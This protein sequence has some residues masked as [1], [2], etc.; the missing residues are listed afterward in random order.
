M[1]GAC[2]SAMQLIIASLIHVLLLI[3]VLQSFIIA[4]VTT[5]FRNF[6]SA[7]S[8]YIYIN[9]F[10]TVGCLDTTNSLPRQM[11]CNFKLYS[12]GAPIAYNINWN[13]NGWIIWGDEINSWWPVPGIHIRMRSLL[14]AI[15]YYCCIFLLVA[16]CELSEPERATANSIES[17]L[18]WEKLWI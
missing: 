7:I 11:L 17:I 18:K 16:R 8:Y 5:G 1:W 15:C 13:G 9:L 10:G 6:S 12:Y 3:I 14:T 4:Y 2:H